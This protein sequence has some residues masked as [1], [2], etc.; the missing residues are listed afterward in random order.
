VDVFSSA[1]T[2]V[3]ILLTSYMNFFLA[4]LLVSGRET[5]RDGVTFPSDALLSVWKADLSLEVCRFGGDFC[6]APVRRREDAE[7]NRNSGVKVQIDD[8]S[9]QR[10]LLECL[11]KDRKEDKK[12]SLASLGERRKGGKKAS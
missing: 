12:G 10:T 5:G 6:V 4:K 2:V 7:G 9:V 3:T 1:R 11:S 8:L